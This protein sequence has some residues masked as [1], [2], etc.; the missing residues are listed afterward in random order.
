MGAEALMNNLKTIKHATNSCGL[1]GRLSIFAALWLGTFFA[2]CLYCYNGKGSLE[3]A[4]FGI[5]QFPFL[6]M[7]YA[8]R[9]RKALKFE[10][11][12]RN[13]IIIPLLFF[14]IATVLFWPLLLITY[15]I[16]FSL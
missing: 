7:Y 2:T 9:E 12:R 11:L 3:F 10:L 14:I 5:Y 8:L 16:S 6:L 13:P 15:F 4:Q 1:I